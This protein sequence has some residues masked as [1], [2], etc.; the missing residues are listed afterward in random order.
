MWASDDWFWFYFWLVEKVVQAFSTNQIVKLS[1]TK[2]NTT[3]LSTL[4]RKLLYIQGKNNLLPGNGCF[5]TTI[6]WQVTFSQKFEYNFLAVSSKLWL[7][8]GSKLN[9]LIFLRLFEYFEWIWI[10]VGVCVF[11]FGGGGGAEGFTD[12]S[13]LFVPEVIYN[14]R[15]DLNKNSYGH[16]LCPSWCLTAIVVIPFEVT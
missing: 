3:L 9:K 6:F 16:T 15:E 5:M 7:N 14:N 11:F 8:P 12:P 10:T 13:L 2:A 1:K 4:N